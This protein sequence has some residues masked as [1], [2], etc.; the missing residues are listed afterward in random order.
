MTSVGRYLEYT[1]GCSVHW[2]FHTDSVV[3]PM[4]FPN[5]YHDIPRCT[6]HP[7]LYCTPPVYCTYI[8]QGEGRYYPI[9][10]MLRVEDIK[11][12]DSLQTYSGWRWGYM[13]FSLCTEQES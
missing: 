4:T 3:F 11:V 2:G 5:I 12:N 6:E 8:L 10:I 13:L 7:S 9:H 1:G